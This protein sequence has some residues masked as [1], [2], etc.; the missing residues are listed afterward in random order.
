MCWKTANHE[1]IDIHELRE[2][3]TKR[4]FKINLYSLCLGPFLCL[5]LYLSGKCREQFDGTF[6]KSHAETKND[7]YL[8]GSPFFFY[9]SLMHTDHTNRQIENEGTFLFVAFIPYDGSL[10]AKSQAQVNICQALNHK[11]SFQS[12]DDGICVCVCVLF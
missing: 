5:C 12:N 9:F 2:R 8:H 1:Y 3:S 4:I 11:C 7:K 10:H 6:Y